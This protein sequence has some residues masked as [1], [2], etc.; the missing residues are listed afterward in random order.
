MTSD[1]QRPFPGRV[2]VVVVNY[3]GADDTI[4]CLRHLTHLDFPADRLELICVDNAS[5]DDSMT[6]LREGAPAGAV[7][8]QSPRN[9]G[10]T[11]GCNLGVEH[12]TGEFIAFINN[13]ARP[14][15][16]WA[17]EAVQVLLR[18]ST[19][20]CVASK[21]LDWEGTHVDFVD[22]ALTWYGMGYKPAAGTPYEG[23]HEQPQDVLFATGSAMVVRADAFRA[24]AGFDERFFM[25]YED[26]DLGWRLNLM[27][28]RVRYVPT[29]VVYHKHHATVKRF[30]EH[31]E[32]FLLERNA[33]M[34]LYKNVSD[35]ALA[36]L[37]APAMALSVRRSLAVG[38]ADPTILDLERGGGDPAETT[39]VTKR[40]LTGAYAIDS[41]VDHLPS[42]TRTRETIQRT[43]I[44]SD[45]QLRPLLRQAIEP[46]IANDRYLEGHQVLV[47]AFGV[48][49][50]FTTG[51]RILVITGDPLSAKLAGPA[52]RA[53]HIAAA[54]AVDHDVR[55]ISTAGCTIQPDGFQAAGRG[56][57]ELRPDVAW[58]DVVIFQ[59]FLLTGAPWLGRTDKILV[60][61]LYDPYQLEQLEQTRG[62]ELTGR[63]RDI[64]STTQAL[65]EQLLRG[66]FF[67]CASEQQRH[68]WLGQLAGLGRLN[69]KTYDQDPSLLSLL[70]VVPSGLPS[71][72]PLKSSS[73]IKGG[74]VPGIGEG[75]KVILWAGGIYNWLDPL[76]LLRAVGML[77]ERRP[78]VR[79]F[80]L[81]TQHPNASVPTMGMV[82]EARALSD[83][84]GL[85]GKFVFFNDGWVDYDDR[86]NYLLDA[87]LGV[88][89]HFEHIEA[90][91]SFRTRILDYLW[92]GL[93]MVLTAGDGFADL[94]TARQLGMAVPERDVDALVGALERSLYDEDFVAACRTNVHRVRP[95]FTWSAVLEPLVDFCRAPQRASDVGE[96]RLAALTAAPP[97]PV[98]G[99]L[100]LARHYLREGGTVE[101]VRRCLGRIRRTVSERRG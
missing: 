65:N 80:F 71:E 15:R 94:V 13:D 43:R 72:T 31:S 85:T 37:L 78:D 40:S 91:F 59:G 77:S 79:L 21:V 100:A 69:P 82:A 3:C 47:D 96:P 6:R 98:S 34:T 70:A 48:A 2:S 23:T 45:R 67:I 39:A 42:L 14:D 17:A 30:G 41:F 57:A 20:G 55:L 68:F 4:A 49:E 28:H 93:P 22:A 8:V 24:A 95:E 64:A 56:V 63:A 52:I 62:A 66:D 74:A 58:A 36:R 76:T 26:V 99:N 1:G 33:L 16:R 101:L 9:S 51:R 90:T 19:I 83:S 89:T 61:D 84:L 38:E 32:W 10:F 97:P 11:G 7:L 5:A 87:D 27:G 88:S 18:D 81:G 75:D 86:H 54:L 12:A 29:S 46:A 53:Y 35:E 73:P 44:R 25:F 92:A 60:P 50:H